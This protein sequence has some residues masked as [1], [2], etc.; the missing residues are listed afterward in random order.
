METW[1]QIPVLLSYWLKVKVYFL[2]VNFLCFLQFLELDRLNSYSTL[3]LFV[4]VYLITSSSK[5][6]FEHSFYNPRKDFGRQKIKASTSNSFS[7]YCSSLFSYS[8]IWPPN[9][10]EVILMH[11]SAK[12][13]PLW[14]MDFLFCILREAGEFW[15]L[16]MC[17]VLLTGN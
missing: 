14:Q 17:N 4:S 7:F 11:L 8:F 3:L 13:W 9:Y 6:C 10:S 12:Q 5:N 16:G 15:W 1:P 2:K